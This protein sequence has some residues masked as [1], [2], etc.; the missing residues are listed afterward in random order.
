VPG[1]SPCRG[2]AVRRVVAFRPVM[3][4]VSGN[5]DPWIWELG[6]VLVE[7]LREAAGAV[8]GVWVIIAIRASNGLLGAWLG[9]F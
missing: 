2:R 9:E 7:R 1:P 3:G 5:L 4:P 8:S 6:P